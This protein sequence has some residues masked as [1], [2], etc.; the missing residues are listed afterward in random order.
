[1]TSGV[2]IGKRVTGDDVAKGYVPTN[3]LEGTLR[4]RRQ[5]MQNPIARKSRMPFRDG[6]ATGRHRGPQYTESPEFN[7][8]SQV[9]GRIG[10]LKAKGVSKGAGRFKDAVAAA[11]KVPGRT[12]RST[13]D[14][15]RGDVERGVTPAR[16]A[17]STKDALSRLARRP[18]EK[19]F[20]RQSVAPKLAR[21]MPAA[22]TNGRRFATGDQNSTKIIGKGEVA[23]FNPME[24]FHAFRGGS[25]AGLM[26]LKPKAILPSSRIG[27]L[28]PAGTKALNAGEKT[29]A[30]VRTN[31]KPLAIGAGVTGGVG[32]GYELSKAHG[33]PEDA[34]YARLGALSAGA[35]IGAGAAGYHAAKGPVK[36]HQLLRDKNMRG[37]LSAKAA[38]PGTKKELQALLRLL[39][40]GHPPTLLGR[41]QAVLGAGSL[42][43]AGLSVGAARQASDRRW[44]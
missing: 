10:Q 6:M 12:A 1:M 42:G 14:W 4:T 33:D 15:W 7:F 35:G 44:N 17:G 27:S 13:R 22:G 29:G 8:G 32:A 36:V 3:A 39:G 23:K 30:F 40:N 37:A 20:G 28:S 41:K 38:Q 31:R 43:L 2:T 9:G 21:R 26:G 34:R 24:A 25:K 18:V 11:P 16:G 19:G 5:L